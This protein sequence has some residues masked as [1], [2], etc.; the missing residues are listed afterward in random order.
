MP[1]VFDFGDGVQLSRDRETT[2]FP[3]CFT[4]ESLLVSVDVDAS[5]VEFGVAVLFEDV[6]DGLEFGNG[7]DA[8]LPAFVLMGVLRVWFTCHA[9]IAYSATSVR[10]LH[11]E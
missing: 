5:C 3:S 11:E 8:C 10:E 9:R 1:A 2:V 7:V 4:G 6:E